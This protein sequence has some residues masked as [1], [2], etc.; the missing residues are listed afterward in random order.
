MTQN[1]FTLIEIV[2][3]F[4]IFAALMAL[5]LPIGIDT[6]RSYL[7]TSDTSLVLSVLGRAQEYS[8][9]NRNVAPHGVSFQSGKMVVFQGGSY[10]SRTSGY[11]EDF[12]ESGGSTITAPSEVVFSQL[13]GNPT[14]VATVT[15]SEGTHTRAV[16]INEQ[17]AF[18]W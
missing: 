9:S 13:S 4:G 17:G 1:G 10:A 16:T 11:D 15:I 14:S 18:L 12:P 3:L 7:L 6:Y 2:I 5:G 8:F